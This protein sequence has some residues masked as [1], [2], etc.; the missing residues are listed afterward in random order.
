MS[1]HGTIGFHGTTIIPRL[2]TIPVKITIASPVRGDMI[3][4]LTNVLHESFL[5]ALDCPDMTR[6]GRHPVMSVMNAEGTHSSKQLRLRMRCAT[7]DSVLNIYTD[8]HVR[9][10]FIVHPSRSSIFSFIILPMASQQPQI[11][12]PIAPK[13]HTELSRYE[14]VGKQPRKL[15]KEKCDSCRTAK[16]KVCFFKTLVE[17]YAHQTCSI[18]CISTSRARM[19]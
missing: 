15:A 3:G 16:V 13:P 10:P 8:G 18:V 1:F 12:R 4:C 9:G 14:R 5:A 19:P 17:E 2:Q 6:G 7:C 11:L